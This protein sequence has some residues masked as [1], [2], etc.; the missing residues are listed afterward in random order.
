MALNKWQEYLDEKGKLVEKPKTEKVAD[1][2]GKTP[3]APA[4]PV[5]KGKNWNADYAANGDDTPSP[6]KVGSD[7]NPIKPETGGFADQGD[8]KLV[9]EPDTD[10]DDADKLGGK[11][12]ST[13][14]KTKTEAFLQKT[15]H[16]EFNDFVE[17]MLGE[18]NCNPNDEDLPTVT[19]YAAGKFHPYPPE[20]IN[21]VAALG[22]K[23]EHVLYNLVFEMKNQGG[24]GKLLEAVL[25]HPEAFDALSTLLES[26]EY[27]AKH[28]KKLAS[29]MHNRYNRFLEE[30]AA[31]SEHV[32]PPMTLGD[33]DGHHK[34]GPHDDGHPPMHPD[35]EEH[36]KDDDMDGEHEDDEE[37]HDDLEPEADPNDPN[38]PKPP[39]KKKFA[40]NNMLD[41]MAGH[42]PMRQAMKKYM[43]AF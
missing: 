35:D 16:M 41:A 22:K 18:C 27:G 3:A 15:K 2:P 32:A 26:D 31:I 7:K 36:P 12:V 24:L 1:Y 20:A 13:W 14:P 40:H 9:Y 5:T 10:V 38:A 34:N 19:A 4:K 17:Y 30:H 8:K 23:N 11:I 29:A 21:Y 28:C 42:E 33:E 25:S 37:H 43:G 6:Y 39:L